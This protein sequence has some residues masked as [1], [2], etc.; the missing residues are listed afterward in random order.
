[1]GIGSVFSFVFF[2][3]VFGPFALLLWWIIKKSTRKLN[4]A[5]LQNERLKLE[6][7]VNA[8]LPSL[9]PLSNPDD[10]AHDV[11]SSYSKGFSITSEGCIYSRCG[12][13]VLAFSAVHRGIYT[14]ERIVLKSTNHSFYIQVYKVDKRIELNGRTFGYTDG[15]KIIYD[16]NK[17][18]IGY[19]VVRKKN[20][21]I[22]LN[23]RV[24][25]SLNYSEAG[26][27]KTLNMFANLSANRQAAFN[28][29]ETLEDNL[30]E[31][32]QQWII[33]LTAY[34][35]I[36]NRLLPPAPAVHNGRTFSH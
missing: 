26:I 14:N 17:K 1:M 30:S 28:I 4:P 18:S 2:I 7:Y 19:I 13:P 25:A 11:R 5:E 8:L 10:I 36:H 21:E 6:A 22:H 9:A 33:L 34:E 24:V 35:M 12:Q 23:G 3:L 29:V 27:T 15:S 32:E 31:E 16:A 20:F